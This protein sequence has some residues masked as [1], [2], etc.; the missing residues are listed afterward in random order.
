MRPLLLL[1]VLISPSAGADEA[2]VGVATNFS[3]VLEKLSEEFQQETD[4]RISIA[5]GSSGKLYAQILNGGPYD[6]FLS[7]DDALPER[8]ART[9]FGVAGSRFTYAVGRLALW[10]PGEAI[11][12]TD[13]REV[14]VDDRIRRLAIANPA[15]APYGV[16]A[17]N[18]LQALGIWPEMHGKIV[19]GENIGQ[20][21]ALVATGNADAGLVAMS[22]LVLAGEPPGGHFIELPASA[23]APIRQDGILLAHGRE[24]AAA[25]E[26]MVFLQGVK[27]RELI[28]AS[29]YSVP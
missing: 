21:Y 6:L 9:A 4:H 28:A 11:T 12:S 13:L 15:L 1:L 5:G 2:L 26:F 18:V 8:L 16:A 14:L 17:R 3:A 27:A 7:A 20:A 29:G 23:Y 19:M 24:N 10:V 25:I 22:F